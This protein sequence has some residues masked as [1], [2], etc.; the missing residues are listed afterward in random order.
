MARIEFDTV[1]YN[2][3][4]ASD[5]K[6]IEIIATGKEIETSGDHY[7]KEIQLIPHKTKPTNSIH[8]VMSV[9]DGELNDIAQGS[10]TDIFYLER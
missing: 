2:R 3:L 10:D 5:F 1:E 8:Y 6:F 7:K 4:L 9:N